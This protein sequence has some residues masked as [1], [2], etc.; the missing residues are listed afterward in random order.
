MSTNEGGGTTPPRTQQRYQRVPKEED[1]DN[2]YHHDYVDEHDRFQHRNDSGNVGGSN[3]QVN[4]GNKSSHPDHPLN[5]PVL[6]ESLRLDTALEGSNLSP[7]STYREGDQLNHSTTK[8]TIITTGGEPRRFSS[9]TYRDEIERDM[10]DEE[11]GEG[12]PPG[13]SSSSP[14][15]TRS[16]ESRLSPPS[17]SAASVGLGDFDDWEDDD[18]DEAGLRRYHLRIDRHT[19]VPLPAE[20]SHDSL[21]KRMW[22]SFLQLQAAASQRRAAR[23]LNM[24]SQSWRYQLHACLLTWCCDATDRGIALVMVW[25]TVWLFIGFVGRMGKTWWTTGV[26]LFI[27][28]VTARRFF[29]Y[30]QLKRTQRRQRLST[31]ELGL[32]KHARRYSDTTTTNNNNNKVARTIS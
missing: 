24:P 1:E 25:L 18:D 16:H 17:T 14:P 15:L 29:E 30:L 19:T 9:S 26:L 7:T 31:V 11:K 32:S 5:Q 27:I 22:H 3:S 10:G 6:V 2:Y 13:S 21:P 23:L 12:G 8:S 4:G 28:R 20:F